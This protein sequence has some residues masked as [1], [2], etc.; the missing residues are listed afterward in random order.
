[1]ARSKAP[2]DPIATNGDA[3]PKSSPS[4][5]EITDPHDKLFREA[6]S[7]PADAAGLLR[8]VLPTA[9]ANELALDDLQPQPGSF[10]DEEL[11]LSQSDVLLLT[12][13]RGRDAYV[14]VLFE[15]KS[16][17]DRWAV[18]QLLRYI[19][20]I[21]ERQLAA[22]PRPDALA[23]VIPVLVHHGLRR[24]TAPLSL[25]EL[26][27]A[28]LL[29]VE[30][31]AALTPNF[32]AVLDDLTVLS[33]EALLGRALSEFGVLA[34]WALRD[35]R[36]SAERILEG[37]TRLADLLRRLWAGPNGE[38]AVTLLVT[39][40]WSV[41]PDLEPAALRAKVK[42]AVPETEELLM[43]IAE[44]YRQEGRQQGLQQGV[45]QGLLE[46]QRRTLERQLARKFGQLTDAARARLEAADGAE[47]EQVAERLLAADTLEEVFE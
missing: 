26:F 25:H 11:R 47:L 18:F 21:W 44:R 34:L 29:T 15:H 2:N 46:G 6:L 30:G 4:G 22:E 8:A 45:V 14:Y 37:V 36:G 19:T 23:P 3:S 42:Q 20:R 27:D 7:N 1:M 40:L 12:K 17:P 41:S 13:C 31:L 38:R 9:L 28:D 32:T 35:G 43:T 16:S 10:V 33:D 39:Y 5:A 24:W